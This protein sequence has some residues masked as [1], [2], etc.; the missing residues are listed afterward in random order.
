MI[1]ALE[2]TNNRVRARV[3][4]LLAAI[5]DPRGREPLIAML[6]DR[7]ARM[8]LIAARCLARFPSPDSVAAL[9]RT[10]K[11]EK[12]R[13]VRIAAVHGLVEQY[14]GGQD[15]AIRR[16]LDVLLDSEEHCDV[17]VA[18][19]SL[20]RTLRLN[21][22]RS[23]VRRL[24]A[25]ESAVVRQHA[26]NFAAS[27]PPSAVTSP[28]EM[29]AWLERLGEDDYAVWNESVQ[30]LSACGAEVIDPLV[31][32]MRVHAERPE[33]C[34]RAGIVLKSL[35]PRRGR[36]LGQA[37][38]RV[39]EPLPLQTL[40]EVI[41]ALG[42]KSLIYRLKDLIDRLAEYP[43]SENRFDP[44]LRVR[45]KAHVEL[46]RIGSRVAI[47]DLREALNSTRGPTDFDMLSAVAKIGKRDELPLLLRAWRREDEFTRRKIGEAV[48]SIM[49]RERIRRNARILQTLS[50]EERAALV[51]ILPP[52]G[53]RPR[54]VRAQKRG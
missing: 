11:N 4:P 3:M 13:D 53:S 7:N 40:V 9:E 41:G 47:S 10:L 27:P 6:L 44:C 8:R 31:D 18:A 50:A 34:T 32:T 51:D 22:R 36:A 26:L 49:R 19:F 33:Y 5:G 28:A 16:V 23:I 45:A 46:A 38:E 24:C 1:E 2:G 15:G 30:R 14:T 42:E 20:L 48:R 52:A 37:L 35:G 17:R 12:R 25:D 54:R 39:V 29:Q 43:C 21:Q